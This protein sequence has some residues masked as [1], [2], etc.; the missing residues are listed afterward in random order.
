LDEDDDMDYKA[1]HRNE[2]T[3]EVEERGKV[4]EIF[5]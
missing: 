1:L 3:K 2:V 4:N 5:A